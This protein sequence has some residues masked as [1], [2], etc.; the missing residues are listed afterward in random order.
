MLIGEAF[1]AQEAIE[2]R[3]F[4][5]AS[6]WLLNH[7]LTTAGIS[8][9]ECYVTNVLNLQPDRNDLTTLCG[10]KTMGVPALPA[11]TK[12]K[13]LLAQYAPELTRLYQEVNDV[14]PNIIIA[15]GNTPA[16]ALL[17]TTGIK[18]VRGSTTY[19]HPE[20]G[21]HFGVRLSRPFKILPTWHP[22]GVMR[23]YS[24]RPI[25]IADLDKARRNSTFPDVRRPRREL[26]I[27]PSLS[28]LAEFERRYIVGCERLSTDIET[29]GDQITCVGF[30]PTPEVGI[31]IPF[32]SWK[33]S[34]RNYWRTL[35]DEL[36][37]WSYVRRWCRDYPTIFQ[38]GCYDMHRLWRTYGIPCPRVADDTM[39][40]HH[41]LQPEMEKGLG[42][43]GTIYTDEAS[44][45]LMRKAETL[46][47]ED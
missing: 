9:D 3:P 29:M 32:L 40:L 1:G 41:A 47:K 21:A 37:A 14:N 30:A 17:H 27:E 20:A 8:R 6:G 36:T 38:N 44:W 31:V 19:T 23:D 35:D 11:L 28:D 26:W 33:Q 13:H 24:N 15:L 25:L 22:A 43:L 2:G 7:C 18:K 5:G 42:F 10:P 12:G 46:K 45:K 39:L 16:W 34:D 4:V